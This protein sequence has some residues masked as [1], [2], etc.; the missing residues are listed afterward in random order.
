MKMT[1]PQVNSEF[2][3]SNVKVSHK[4]MPIGKLE[5]E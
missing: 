5:L 1:A 4:P 2:I 3:D